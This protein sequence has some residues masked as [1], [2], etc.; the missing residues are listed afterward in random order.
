MKKKAVEPAKKAELL[1][2]TLRDDYN[3]VFKRETCYLTSD[4]Y[5]RTIIAAKN[6]VKICDEI[7]NSAYWWQ[8]KKRLYFMAVKICL[9]TLESEA[10]QGLNKIK[11]E[12]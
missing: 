8:F 3:D 4:G 5:K 1:V 12:E 10:V 11:S 2:M 6:A 7:I 9:F